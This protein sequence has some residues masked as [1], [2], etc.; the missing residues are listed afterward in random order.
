MQRSKEDIINHF[1]EFIF[2]FIYHDIEHC[3]EVRANYAVALA[4]LSYTEY[5]G[6]LISGYLGLKN[7]S[8]SNFEEALKYF[9][10]EYSDVNIT[11]KVEYRDE[12]GQIKS[13]TGIYGLFRCGMVHEYFIKGLGTVINNPDGHAEAHRIGVEVMKVE[14]LSTGVE[15]K[16][17][18][19]RTNEYF[20]DFKVAVEKIYKRLILNS[21]PKLLKGFNKS[22]DRIDARRIL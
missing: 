14:M 18:V 3:I 1:Q 8:K 2:D 17:L 9:P 20:R 11:L 15:E 21:D 22:L 5:I 13:D 19:L 4:L 10:K 12:R 6:G 16:L 7:K